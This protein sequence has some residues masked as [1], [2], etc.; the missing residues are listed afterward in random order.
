MKRSAEESVNNEPTES[1]LLKKHKPTPLTLERCLNDLAWLLETSPSSCTAVSLVNHKLLIADNGIFHGSQK[2]NQTIKYQIKFIKRVSK[3]FTTDDQNEKEEYKKKLI[4][5]IL[6]KKINSLF[7][8]ELSTPFSEENK[9]KLT[10]IFP[11]NQDKSIEEI[12]R[13]FSSDHSKINISAILTTGKKVVRQ[14]ERVTSFLEEH[15]ENSL[16][17]VLKKCF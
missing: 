4:K 11:E 8:G 15:K 14:L 5:M 7:K 12:M 10:Q 6:L 3:F 2:D 9:S 13:K 17:S 16:Y 1:R